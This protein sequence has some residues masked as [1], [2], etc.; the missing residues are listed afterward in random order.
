[1]PRAEFGFILANVKPLII[2]CSHVC[3]N[4]AI[5]L[6]WSNLQAAQSYKISFLKTAS[7]S[8]IDNHLLPNRIL[9]QLFKLTRIP[10]QSS[11][12]A[13][14][15][16]SSSNAILYSHLAVL[17]LKFA[18]D[19]FFGRNLQYYTCADWQYRCT[20]Q[21]CSGFKAHC[22]W[23]HRCIKGSFPSGCTCP[24]ARPHSK[25]HASWKADCKNFLGWY[26]TVH[27]AE[28]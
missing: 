25:L 21:L 10:G 12:S 15:E 9:H 2:I 19:L 26:E 24:I 14:L 7:W 20:I 4:S 27:A 28:G 3:W 13:L 11:C 1:M 18:L 16:H 23:E 17:A 5:E 6:I 22:Y 8:S